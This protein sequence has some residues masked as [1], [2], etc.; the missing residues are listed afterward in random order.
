MDDIKLAKSFADSIYD[1]N[2]LELACKYA[3]SNIDK[4]FSNGTWSDVAGGIPILKELF[5]VGKSAFAIRDIFLASK[6]VMF[7]NE[8]RNGTADDKA[9]Q[10]RREAS[11]K[12]E[13]WLY[14]EVERVLAYIE[15]TANEE[16]VP[17]QA[18]IYISYINGK[19]SEDVFKDFLDIMDRMFLADIDQLRILYENNNIN[20]EATE[21]DIRCNRLVSLGL[22]TGKAQVVPGTLSLNKFQI[23][24]LGRK[25]YEIIS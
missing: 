25:F 2:A 15:N 3:N 21:Y 4:L 14:K 19:I 5:P 11:Q 8:I 13:S 17:L 22:A 18:R 23:T 16:K 12:G 20:Y 1:N 6:T 10:K 7:L 9:I 24:N